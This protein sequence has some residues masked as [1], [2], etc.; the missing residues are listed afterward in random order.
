MARTKDINS[1]VLA[2]AA[3]PQPPQPAL[4]PGSKPYVAE[5]GARHAEGLRSENARLKEERAAGGVVLMLDPKLVRPSKKYSNR[6]PQ[7]LSKDDPKLIELAERL[8]SHGQIVPIGVY[9]V[10]G[11]GFEYEIMYGHRRHAACLLL[12]AELPGGF[13]I[14]AI[15]DPKGIDEDHVLQAWY[16]ENANREDVT[17]YEYAQRYSE[18]LK[19]RPIAKQGDLAE[20]LGLTQ[21][22]IAAY[23]A[24]LQL[25]TAVFEAYGSKHAVRFSHIMA[26]SKALREDGPHVLNLAKQLA[27]QSPRLPA[28]E[29]FK[30]LTR[31]RAAVETASKTRLTVERKGRVAGTISDDSGGKMSLKLG[32]LVKQKQGSAERMSKAM[33]EAFE[34]FIDKELT[35]E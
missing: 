19:N 21:G 29:T 15:V 24:I 32:A 20:K 5:V 12:N 8:K 28:A 22:T 16:G 31:P 7:F 17:A 2:G 9:S 27:S 1:F 18:W 13:K 26:L 6:D 33:K 30:V 11:D 10:S 14:K 34:V 3:E 23:L 35:N 4:P 25:P